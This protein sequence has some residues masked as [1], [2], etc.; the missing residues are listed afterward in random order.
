MSGTGTTSVRSY[1]F[2]LDATIGVVA[3]P[4]DPVLFIDQD[5]GINFTSHSIM[6]SND[7]VVDLFFSFDGINIHGRVAAGESLQQDYRRQKQI[8]LSAPA[9]LDIRFWAW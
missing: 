6:F 5:S 8:W 4:T 9:G 7:G 1:T 2:F 3:F